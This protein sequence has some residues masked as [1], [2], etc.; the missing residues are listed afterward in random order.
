MQGAHH[1]KEPTP[2]ATQTGHEIRSP[3]KENAQAESPGKE[4]HQQE[5]MMQHPGWLL[6]I[7][8][9]II[10]GVSFPRHGQ[11]GQRSVWLLG[12]RV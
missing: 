6:V 10:D 1:V 7:V 8:G 11:D 4:T 2:D 3:A 5:E 12:C 9:L